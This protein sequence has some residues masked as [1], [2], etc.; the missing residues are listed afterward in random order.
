MLAFNDYKELL[1]REFKI[2]YKEYDGLDDRYFC[3][4]VL[5][6]KDKSTY[7]RITKEFKV[8][9]N[10]KLVLAYTLYSTLTKSKKNG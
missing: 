3:F 8:S 5:D 4:E 7:L 9:E 10:M 6:P 2:F 1:Q